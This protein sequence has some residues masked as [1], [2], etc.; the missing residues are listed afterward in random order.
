[1]SLISAGGRDFTPIILARRLGVTSG[2]TR[3]SNDVTWKK[4]QITTTLT[5]TDR[6]FKQNHINSIFS[7]INCILSYR[8]N[9]S[10]Y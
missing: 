9:V 7:F 3:L 5:K 2:K 8:N 10:M 6:V 4:N 1:M